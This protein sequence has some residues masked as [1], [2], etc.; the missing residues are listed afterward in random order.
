MRLAGCLTL[1]LSFVLLAGPGQAQGLISQP[2]AA[3]YGLTR[4]WFAQIGSPQVTG[5]LEYVNYVDGLLLVQSR[6]GM[7]TALD[8]ETGRT[9]WETRVGTTA[10]SSS[11][12]AANSKFVV[13]LSGTTL[14]VINRVDGSIV[15]QKRVTRAP[16][17]GP[18]VT[19]T[20]VFVPMVSGLVEG[21]DL[22]AG[23]RQTPWNYQATGRILTPPMTTRL[24]VSWTTD[25]GYFYV[26][27]PEAGGI[28]YRLESRGAIHSRP[29]AWSPMLYATS[30]DG[31]VYAIEETKGAIRW[32]QSIGEPIY[33][34]PVAVTGALL[35]IPEFGGMYCLDP[36]NGKIRWHTPAIQQFVAASPTRIY[37]AD[38]LGALAILD[39]GTG[40]RLGALPVSG[41][42]T[43]HVNSRSD[44]IYLVDDN[45][46]VQCLHESQLTQPALHIQ[47]AP[48]EDGRSTLPKRGVAAERETPDT[49]MPT[50]DPAEA[51]AGD[52]PF[53]TGGDAPS[54]DGDDPFGAPGDAAGSDADNPFA[55]P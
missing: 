19:E 39:L 54:A 25:N 27:D 18:G 8:A 34:Q 35:V 44:R 50:E 51:P 6:L 1:V 16:G 31:F 30:A 20:H 22:E 49:D 15:W 23:T 48:P 3:R 29:A 47:P 43:K 38:D 5:H 42:T 10:G 26:A 9:L 21:Y 14:Y 11:E 33:K 46:L 12:P 17:A 28:K 24:T 40:A 2:T 37:A 36:A 13:V 53:D 7:L 4:A 32:K 41:L 45:C 55:T 52:N